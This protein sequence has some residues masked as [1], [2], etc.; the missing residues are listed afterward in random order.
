MKKSYL[1]SFLGM[2]VLS[3]GFSFFSSCEIGLGSAVDT[4]APELVIETPPTSAVIR[5]AFA[6][7][8]SWKDDG[9]I[10]SISVSL[11]NTESGAI[12]LFSGTFAE[13]PK[14]DDEDN[15]KAAGSWSVAVNPVEEDLIDGSY[16][17]TITIA[18]NGGHNTVLTRAFII[19]N[20]AP[21][22]VLTRPSTDAE[23]A[24]SDTYGQTFT[25]EGQAADT[26]NV[27]LI[28][29]E[30]Y[31]DKECTPES[32]IHTVPLKNVP[33]SINMDVAN[34][35]SGDTE[36]DYYKIYGSSS[37]DAG[38]KDFYCKLVAYD[39]AQRYP[40]GAAQ[41]EA[42]QK[43]N[44]TSYYYLYKDI[45]TE[46]LQDYKINEV[47]NILNRTFTGDDSSR[48]IKKEAV[49]GRL[50]EKIK[51]KGKFTLNPK[52]NPTFSVTGRSP[53]LKD[54]SDFESASNN[55]SDGSQIVI[56]VSPGLDGILLEQSSLKVYAVECD[57]SGNAIGSQRIYPEA[58]AP[59]ESGTSYRFITTI[60]RD[61]GLEINKTYILGVEGYD[62][63]VSRNPIE[64]NGNGYGFKMA[65]SGKAPTLT[66]SAPE[67]ISYVKK[68]GS[69]T[70]TG[71]VAVEAGLPE[72]TLYKGS[73]VIHNFEFVNGSGHNENGE[74]SYDFSYTYS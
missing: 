70:F 18:D 23:S 48:S 25:L 74:T 32:Y 8:G 16:E 26:N 44:S 61:K 36:N 24:S 67:S 22:I 56:E 40:V 72:L 2:A 30:I 4:E 1:Y 53:L 15:S 64:P 63:S 55:I 71:S 38:A 29:V 59:I 68:G 58:G 54:G 57:A 69:I 11:R 27:S 51:S 45:A 65:P 9:S 17:A 31:R 5:D 50:A 14:T 52:N 37:T 34:F 39:G 62:Q 19:D 7:A 3:F 66:V 20:T 42:D 60:S 43:G 49:L 41:T 12:S 6:I 10:A 46:I 73:D 28:E 47:Y 21:I 35:K 33:N 13:N